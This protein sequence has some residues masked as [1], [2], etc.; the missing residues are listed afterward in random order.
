MTARRL[1]QLSQEIGNVIVCEGHCPLNM[2]M[3]GHCWYIEEGIVDVFL[4]EMTDGIDQHAPQHL[5][6]A[7]AGRFLPGIAEYRDVNTFSLIAKGLPGTKLRQLSNSDLDALENDEL[8]AHVDE[9]LT[10][11]SA[12]LVRDIRPLPR[13]NALLVAGKENEPLAGILSTRDGVVW[14]E[15]TSSGHCLYLNLVELGGIGQETDCSL[16][17]ITSNS[18]LN[19]LSEVEVSTHTSAV[20]AHRGSLLEELAG[21][22]EKMFA[23]TRI[24]RNLATVD[25][26]NIERDRMTHQKI[27]EESARTELYDVIKRTRKQTDT[28]YDCSLYQVLEVVGKRENINFIF[29][30]SNG[31]KV[32][33]ED[34]TVLK[35]VIDISG[36]RARQISLKSEDRWWIGDSGSIVAYRNSDGQPIALVPGKLGNYLEVDPVNNTTIRVTADV[37]ENYQPDGW[38]FYGTLPPRK[39]G[40]KDLFSLARRGIVGDFVRVIF[41][42]ILGGLITLAPAISVGIV[43]DEIFATGDK[44]LLYL[45]TSMLVVLAL[46]GA[47]LHVF[48]GLAMQRLE[49]KAASRLDAAFWDRLIRIPQQI[50]SRFPASDLAKRGL[51][52]QSMRDEDWLVMTNAVMSIV[53]LLPMFFI[54]YL[55]DP[56]MGWAAIILGAIYFGVTIGLSLLQMLPYER[57][58]KHEQR[59]ARSLLQIVSGI[60]KLRVDH[61]ERIAYSNVAEEFRK[62]KQEEL[63]LSEAK[64]YLSS[65]SAVLPLLTAAVL[66]LCVSV[67]GES[68]LSVGEFLVIF[69]LFTTF[70]FA[71]SNLAS[72]MDAF[73][74]FL[75]AQRQVLPI[76]EETPQNDVLGEPVNTL[77]GEIVFDNISFRYSPD[78][79][80][81]LEDVTL[82]A[83]PGEFVAITGESGSGKSTLFRLAL[84]L[85]QPEIGAVYYDGRDLKSLNIKQLRTHIGTVP[86]NVQTVP[87]DIWDNIVGENSHL[88]TDD[89]W[90][91]AK[92]AAIDDEIRKMPLGML[93]NVGSGMRVLSGGESQRILI[94][95]AIVDNPLFVFFDEAT[96]WLDNAKQAEVMKN[97]MS[98]TST[99]LVIAHRLSTLIDADRIYVLDAGK[100][101]QEGSYDELMSTEG[102][103]RE[104][105]QRQLA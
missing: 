18:W 55:Y 84:G 46:I 5:L 58:K 42:G 40:K 6:R 16:I 39:V 48:K 21:F 3:S 76:L 72:S 8:A 102:K 17:P 74:A 73:V 91:A 81:V 104:L 95:H 23:L 19:A 78:G 1:N 62:Q 2:S 52:F 53:F 10:D 92:F 13:Q 9:W 20:L 50:L 63:K 49:V 43:V 11:I 100:V 77:S 96:N 67:L 31:V 99:R 80:W 25:R 44:G 7:K 103:F 97:F 56:A 61:A 89:A 37:A 24:N 35:E 94:A 82:R 47:L 34:R 36:V 98:L 79:P 27:K 87:E 29:P 57:V 28:E 65:F 12:A 4:I 75:P 54:T 38:M 45:I 90:D 15:K 93:T 60:R 33:P 70:Q 101:V 32:H 71:V 88:T 69:F 66:I 26:A 59:V 14:V 30:E 41:A 64:E 105:V 22:H 86:Q 68:T 51:A 85:E 83:R